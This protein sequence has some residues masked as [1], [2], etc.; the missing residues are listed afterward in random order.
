MGC[1]RVCGGGGWGG[2]QGDEPKLHVI[3]NVSIS[4]EAAC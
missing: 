3:V 4:C 1:V 2:E